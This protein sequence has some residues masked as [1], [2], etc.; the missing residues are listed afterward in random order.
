MVLELGTGRCA[1]KDT[2][3]QEGRGLVVPMF[4]RWP[5]REIAKKGQY[6]LVASLKLNT[7]QSAK[8]DIGPGGGG[9]GRLLDQTLVG[10]GH[11]HPI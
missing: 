11:V 4:V 7:G 1:R 9:E 5:P 6:L 8:K 10:E 2:G 3:P